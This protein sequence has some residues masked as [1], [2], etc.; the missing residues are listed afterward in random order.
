MK[1]DEDD[2]GYVRYEGRYVCIHN[3]QDTR[4]V[5]GESGRGRERK[6]RDTRNEEAAPYRSTAANE[7]RSGWKYTYTFVESAKFNNGQIE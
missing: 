5:E 1:M 6:I 4:S 7:M 3:T 2:T